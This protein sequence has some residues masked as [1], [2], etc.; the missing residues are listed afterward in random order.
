MKSYLYKLSKNYNLIVPTFLE[1]LPNIK[2]LSFKDDSGRTWMTIEPYTSEEIQITIM[3]DYAWDGCSPKINVL[4]LFHIGSPDGVIDI[5]TGK[6]KTYYASLVHDALCQ[7]ISGI[8]DM[9]SRKDID[10]L[11]FKSLK[12]SNFK[13][14]R[15]Y[16][17]LVRIYANLTLKK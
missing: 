15:L 8:E 14:S 9:C 11:F 2:S 5:T 17:T 1:D 3:K 10:Q 12:E 13:L 7:F 4:D 16:Y 6:P